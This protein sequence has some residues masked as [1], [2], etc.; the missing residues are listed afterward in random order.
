MRSLQRI[1]HARPREEAPAEQQAKIHKLDRRAARRREQRIWLRRA[2]TLVKLA[3]IAGAL[4]AGFVAMTGSRIVADGVVR[5]GV[6]NVTAP[7][8]MRV[9]E[10]LTRVGETIDAGDPIVRLEP[11]EVD[12]DRVVL[13]AR[14]EAAKARLGWFDAGGERELLGVDQRIDRV[15]AAERNADL[16]RADL[17]ELR[18]TLEVRAESVALATATLERVRADNAGLTASVEARRRSAVADVERAEVVHEL[19]RRNAERAEQLQRDGIRSIADV[20]RAVTDRDAARKT[21]ESLDAIVLEIEVEGSN[22]RRSAAASEAAASR[23]LD[24][25]VARE[26]EAAA[27][28]EAAEAR[29]GAFERE[30]EHHRGMAPSGPIQPDTLRAARRDQLLAEVGVAAAALVAHDEAAA[31]RVLVARTHGVVDELLAVIGEV[32]DVEQPLVRHRDTSAAHVVAYVSPATAADLMVGAECE[33]RCL[34]ERTSAE[35]SVVAVGGVWIQAPGVPERRR[36]ERRVAVTLQL[37]DGSHHFRADAR[38]KAVF[39]ADPWTAARR[40]VQNW[41]GG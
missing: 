25:A 23:E 26:V 24:V 8:R 14:V 12:T 35:A 29:A 38:V 31:E 37:A 41:F 36:D 19:A 20:E 16:A 34:P 18:S 7:R 4:T 32:V 30:A 6:T 1:Q 21:T 33:V 13:L 22:V 15:I 10:W 9:A 17:V 40:R 3:V 27:A 39:R 5:A 28:V 11:V 2:L